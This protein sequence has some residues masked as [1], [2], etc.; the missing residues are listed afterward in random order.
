MRRGPLKTKLAVAIYNMERLWKWRL[1]F[2]LAKMK[3]LSVLE[4]PILRRA[5]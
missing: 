5:W 4:G 2:T 1:G 3:C